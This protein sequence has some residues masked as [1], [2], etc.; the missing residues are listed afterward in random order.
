AWINRLRTT[1][2]DQRERRLHKALTTQSRTPQLSE[3]VRRG[4]AKEGAIFHQLHQVLTT[5]ADQHQQLSRITDD[6]EFDTDILMFKA[7]S[8]SA[9]DNLEHCE[10]ILAG[11]ID[12][13]RGGSGRS[14]IHMPRHSKSLSKDAQDNEPPKITVEYAED[15]LSLEPLDAHVESAEEVDQS[16]HVDADL[17]AMSDDQKRRVL[18]ILNPLKLGTD[19]TRVSLPVFAMQSRSFLEALSD[20]FANAPLLIAVANTDSPE[21]RIIHLVKWYLTSFYEGCRDGQ[22]LKPF[23][24][25]LG[26]VFRCTW[27]VPNPT[28]PAAACKLKVVAEQVSHHPPVSAI[29]VSCPEQSLYFAAH[30]CPKS[31]Y[32]GMSMSAAL[33]GEGRLVIGMKSHCFYSC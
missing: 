27:V 12:P 5:V 8:R 23:N 19:L 14:K 7:T 20:F 31:K 4:T 30:V 25:V 9:V 21:Q 17:E 10:R 29:Y 15:A 6:L 24:P 22:V 18:A 2:E 1:A 32:M 33:I 13:R 11:F 28:D 3:N 26:E 16:S